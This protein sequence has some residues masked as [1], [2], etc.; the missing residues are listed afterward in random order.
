MTTEEIERREAALR[1]VR[2]ALEDFDE[3]QVVV[4]QAVAEVLAIDASGSLDGYIQAV[5]A[6]VCRTLERT[7]RQAQARLAEV[8][9]EHIVE[10]AI[11]DAMK[12]FPLSG[13]IH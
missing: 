6:A 1:G 2:E 8:R 13:I 12:A 10:V 7:L 11:L 9:E 3:S 4:G 5:A